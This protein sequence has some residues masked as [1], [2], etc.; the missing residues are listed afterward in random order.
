MEKLLKGDKIVLGTCYYPE[1]WD[2][3]LWK[4]DLA[5]MKENGL[6]AIRIAEFAWSKFE[7]SEGSYSFGFFDDF[8]EEAAAADMGV[9]FCTPTATPPAWLTEAYP[10]VLNA[11]IDGVL[12]R[13]GGRRHYNYNSPV[14][15]RFTR[16]IVEKL[17]EHYGP[18]PNVIGWQLDNELNCQVDVFYS[19]S[20]TLAFRE[21]LKEKY[22][23]LE[24]LNRAWGNVFWNQEFTAWSEI[25]VPRPT[26]SGSA[27]PGAILDYIRFV[28]ESCRSYARLQSGILRKYLKPGDFITTNGMFGNLDNHRMTGES[29]DFF[30]YDSYPAFAF[31]VGNRNFD[32]AGLNDR[33]WSQ[34][35]SEVR[36]VSPNFGIMEQQ[37]GPPGSHSGMEGPAPK[38][39]QMTLWTMQS[40]AHGA[41]YVSYFRWRTC[42][43]GTEIYWHGILDYSNRDNRRLAELRD[44]YEKTGSI[45]AAAGSRYAAAFGVLR[46]YDNLW[47]S[48]IDSWHGRIGGFSESEIFKAAQLSHTPMDYVYLTGSLTLETLKQYPLLFYPHAVILTEERAALLEAYVRDG[49]ILVLGCRTGYKD[50]TGK[51][52]MVK[53]PGI[54]RDLSGADVLEYS[55]TGPGD[56]M[57]MAD[58]EG[59][60]LE[61]AV[62]N[63]ILAPLGNAKVLGT[64]Q[65]NYYAGKPAL[66]LNECGKGRVYYFGAAFSASAALVFLEKLGIA[67]PHRDT[68]EADQCCE[69]ALRRGERGDFLFILNYAKTPARVNLKKEMKDLY[70][71]RICSGK[72]ELPPF[73]TAVYQI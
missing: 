63:D 67:S 42:A 59:T 40:I 52:P 9:I 45:A 13:H 32:P 6:K 24:D 36:S 26:V 41:D 4:E 34:N 2:R 53:L 60:P 37:S 71:G 23:A 5:R 64:Y 28:S 70:T 15:Q 20:D 33:R 18:H 46:D 31:A 57:I 27:N 17:G 61:A 66:I 30:C 48:R 55:F 68:V 14:Y 49:G 22:A 62:F 1:H 3:K 16:R 43:M 11:R 50:D 73:G 58:W 47:D 21:F 56:G 10:E 19:E 7:P 25:H 38:P 8:M 12:Y 39:G 54:L 69:I 44:I 35:L 65:N 72:I 51:C 29:L